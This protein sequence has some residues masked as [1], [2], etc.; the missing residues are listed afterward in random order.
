MYYLI[1]QGKQVGP[2][3]PEDLSLYRIEP[4]TLVWHDGPNALAD[5]VPAK[6]LPYLGYLFEPASTPSPAPQLPPRPKGDDYFDDEVDDNYTLDED[7][8]DLFDDEEED[9]GDGLTY[10]HPDYVAGSYP[11]PNV[12]NSPGSSNQGSSASGCG[13][14][15]A[16]FIWIIIIGFVL[17]LIFS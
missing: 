14:T 2:I 5:W 11:T 16:V 8:E 9:D 4:D 17:G 13:N 3:A 6:S 7:D 10:S 12:T 15:V 1:I